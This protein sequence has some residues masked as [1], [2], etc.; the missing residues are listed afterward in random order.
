M[1]DLVLSVLFCPWNS[2]VREVNTIITLLLW[3]RKLQ[4][5][6]DWVTWPPCHRVSSKARTW[7]G[8]IPK[9]LLLG[10]PVYPKDLFL[11][12]SKPPL[13]SVRG[14]IAEK[15]CPWQREAGRHSSG[16]RP[17]NGRWLLWGMVQNF[18]TFSRPCP[19]CIVLTPSSIPSRLWIQWRASRGSGSAIASLKDFQPRVQPVLSLHLSGGPP[20]FLPSA[21]PEGQG[22][23]PWHPSASI[24]SSG[25]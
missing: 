5:W 9:L 1:P 4:A 14:K 20:S 24:P 22:S 23:A 11:E 3:L 2:A 16:K 21:S 13:H 17:A 18:K 8:L 10:S 6:R 12:G 25:L 15:L 7:V 19:S